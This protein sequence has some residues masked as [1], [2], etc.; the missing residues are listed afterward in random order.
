MDAEI[1]FFG[2]KC[3]LD[4]V[5]RPLGLIWGPREPHNSHFDPIYTYIYGRG[6]KPLENSTK[7]QI[8]KKVFIFE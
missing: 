3:I 5:L 6:P 7:I 1:M 2:Q 8:S 4:V